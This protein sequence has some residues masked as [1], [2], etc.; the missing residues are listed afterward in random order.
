MISWCIESAKS[1]LPL[2]RTQLMIRNK[3]RKVIFHSSSTECFKAECLLWI[4]HLVFH[5]YFRLVNL[6]GDM[7]YVIPIARSYL[8]LWTQ[9]D[10]IEISSY[11]K[12]VR[13]FLWK[14]NESITLTWKRENNILL[15]KKCTKE[16]KRR[17]KWLWWWITNNHRFLL[18][19]FRDVH[20]TFSIVNILF[21][22]IA[23]AL[24]RILYI[25][26]Q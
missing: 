7:F 23:W 5:V 13:E 14:R 19:M 6:K 24:I 4:N 10:D 16:M 2:I 8:I 22:L 3:G 15:A 17:L 1:T 9:N 26:Y 11:L 18:S 20:A 25:C 12:R 21:L